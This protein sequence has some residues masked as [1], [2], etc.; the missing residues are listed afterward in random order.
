MIV[1]AYPQHVTIAVQFDKPVGKP[2]V[3]NGNRYYICEPTPQKEDLGLG[4]SL[5]ELKKTPYEWCMLISLSRSINKFIF[6]FCGSLA[7][8]C[9]SSS[10]FLVVS[11]ISAKYFSPVFINDN[12]MQSAALL[13]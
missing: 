1:L 5:P 11:F 7:V 9:R 6:S 13:K 4:E 3:Y 2:I 8:F 12:V 10:I